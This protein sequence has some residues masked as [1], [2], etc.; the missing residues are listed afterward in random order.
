M[1]YGF[2]TITASLTTISETSWSFVG[3]LSMPS[4][5]STTSLASGTT[6]FIKGTNANGNSTYKKFIVDRTTYARG[7]LTIYISYNDV[8]TD[9]TDIYAPNVENPIGVITTRGTD[10]GFYFLPTT[11]LNNE[12]P[13]S[14]LDYIRNLDLQERDVNYD[15][16][17][18]EINSAQD[19][20]MNENKQKITKNAD[21]IIDLQNEDVNIYNLLR[22]IADG[23]TFDDTESDA[24][25][26][27]SE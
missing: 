23:G 21:D 20:F 8:Y 9:E 27:E 24:S 19:V 22:M 4:G 26:G 15:R 18:Q 10:E 14:D 11:E 3:R 13:Q 2:M 1:I 7:K 17:M 25:D 6:V 5:E 12:M 16:K